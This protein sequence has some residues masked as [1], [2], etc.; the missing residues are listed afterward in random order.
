MRRIFVGAWWLI[1]AIATAQSTTDTLSVRG[2]IAEALSNNPRIAIQRSYLSASTARVDL[3]RAWESPSF[4]VSWMDVPSSS[5]NPFSNSMGRRLEVEQ[6]IPF[7]GKISAAIDAADASTQSS[8]ARL[9]SA[10]Q[11]IIT[12]L[13]IRLAELT[14]IRR[15]RQINEE[16]R[17]VLEQL[18]SA[19][20]TKYS[21]G[22]AQQADVLR[23]SIESRKLGNERTTLQREQTT[24]EGMLNTL[25]GR[26]VERPWP[27]VP[28]LPWTLPS[29]SLEELQRL[30]LQQRPELL[31]AEADISMAAA[32]LTMA[33]RLFE[34]VHD[35]RL[36]GVYAWHQDSDCSMGDR[37][38][39][40]PSGRAHG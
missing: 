17:G 11:A 33:R 3:A 12:Q 37:S 4:A 5:L 31:M 22:R 21:V 36:L 28:S 16:Q 29:A 39:Q 7:P 23:L 35:A 18:I 26:S 20:R 32:D 13:K 25:L 27:I 9:G 6:M 10:Q 19:V 14:A 1:Q 38:D 40:R 15:R 24:A 30:A 8:R 2:L 34:P